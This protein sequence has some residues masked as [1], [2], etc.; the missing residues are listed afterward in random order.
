MGYTKAT[1]FLYTK[2][3]VYYFS[4][5][6]PSD[7]QG[8]YRGPRIALSLKTK[9]LRV[10]QTRSAALSSKLDEDWL[11]LRWRS[12]NDPFNR[13][14]REGVSTT[15]NNS[16]A[17][18]LSEAKEIYL[19]AKA[20]GRSITF[21]QAAERSVGCLTQLHGDRPIDLYTRSDV[22]ELRDALLERGL[23]TSSVRRTLNSVRAIV[24]FVCLE[25]GLPEVSSFSGVYL[26]ESDGQSSSKRQ[27][28]AVPDIRRVQQACVQMDDEARWL[29]A[30]IS[31]TGM[32]L[33]EATGL[34]KEDVVL[35]AK[36][37]HI[38]LRP[39][40]WRRL[41]TKG[42][43][44]VVPLVGSSLWAARQAVQGSHLLFLFPKYCS[45]REC[46]ANS[47]SGALNKWLS[48]RLPDGCVVHSFRHSMR[49]RLAVSKDTTPSSPS[50]LIRFHSLKYCQGE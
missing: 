38:A 36:Y 50:S 42:S 21:E 49:D 41:K 7:L 10:A 30:L 33:A 43:E 8:H 45:E 35:D 15:A 28:I 3:G 24:N 14:L 6:V 34:M 39:H 9:S 48:P 2:R 11:T 13:F 1:Q 20:T 27:P 17:P 25:L 16:F 32:R 23:Q 37:P 47:A 44:R 29:I 40:P 12:S 46:K 26:G 31:D 4:R 5:R 22:N 19:K 18:L